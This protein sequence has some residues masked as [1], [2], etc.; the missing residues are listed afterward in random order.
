MSYIDLY[1]GFD[2][3]SVR[4][5]IIYTYIFFK[6]I[7]K[8]KRKKK[9]RVVVFYAT[10]TNIEMVT[11]LLFSPC[12]V[13]ILNMSCLIR[14]KTLSLYNSLQESYYKIKTKHKLTLKQKKS[15]FSF[16]FL[17]CVRTR[18]WLYVKHLFQ[19]LSRHTYPIITL[20]FQMIIKLFHFVSKQ[21]VLFMW[22][23]LQAYINFHS[24]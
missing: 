24:S 11:T 9:K 21:T 4:L 2:R 22:T 13:S 17:C 5:A 8:V 23:R 3:T 7:S 14:T 15:F 12:T 18:N 19:P 16:C 6:L 20:A 1:N 10:N